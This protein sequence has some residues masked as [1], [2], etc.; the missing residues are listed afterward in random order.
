V[1]NLNIVRS[2]FIKNILLLFLCYDLLIK[3]IVEFTNIPNFYNYV[4]VFKV[5][6]VFMI[7]DF[8]TNKNY[9]FLI[10][11]LISSY[12][13]TQLY[14][15]NTLEQL[16]VLFNG[17]F[18]LSSI[19]PLIFICFSSPIKH[20]ISEQQLIRFIWFLS[21]S[22]IFILIGLFFDINLFKSY[23]RSSGTRFGYSGF[24]L[25]HHEIGYIYFI[26]LNILYYNFKKKKNY[27]NIILLLFIMT[28]SLF[29]GTKKTLFLMLF[30]YFYIIIDNIKNIKRILI[31]L[32][33]AIFGVVLF[34]DLLKKYFLFF[35]S[36]YQEKGALSSFL[37]YRDVLLTENLYPY[38]YNNKSFFNL[39]FG[40]PEFRNHRSEMEFFDLLLFYGISGII[41]YVLFIKKILK[42]KNRQSYFMVFSLLIAALFSGNLFISVNV[43]FLMY[44][45]IVYINKPIKFPNTI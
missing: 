20:S 24:L 40:W 26:F 35:H 2:F 41:C 4:I 43:I 1:S 39:L 7:L 27:V 45:T 38:I 37:S 8:K 34:F 6:L 14:Y 32:F 21:I 16:N 19:L 42:G 30:F 10:I 23:F 29:T 22:S 31:V 12:C 3:I 36:I 13:F 9:L 18:F 44:I 25:Y 33:S 5:I 15:F 17:Y 28:V 11:L